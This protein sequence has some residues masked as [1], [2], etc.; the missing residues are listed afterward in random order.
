[1][2]QHVRMRRKTE[3]GATPKRATILRQPAVVKDEP[4]SDV[5]TKGDA[6]SWWRLKAT[7]RLYQRLRSRWEP[8]F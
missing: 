4:R 2:P 5:N 7:S 6:G 8:R 3:F 1:M